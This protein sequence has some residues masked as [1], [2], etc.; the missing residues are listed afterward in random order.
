M[1]EYRCM[2]ALTRTSEVVYKLG[3][4][5][6]FNQHPWMHFNLNTI[7]YT[8]GRVNITVVLESQNQDVQDGEY[9]LLIY[10]KLRQFYSF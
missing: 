4:T 3:D 1:T 10:I 7:L 2:N 5:S 9:Q 8:L 6:C